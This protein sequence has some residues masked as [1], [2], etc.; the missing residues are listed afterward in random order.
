MIKC[1]KG[2]VEISGREPMVL[3]ELSTTIFALKKTLMEDLS[4]KD[5]EGIIAEA[6]EIGFK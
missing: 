1:D 2:I 5:A 6:V 3:A 4:E